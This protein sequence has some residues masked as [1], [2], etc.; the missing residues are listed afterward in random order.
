MTDRHKVGPKEEEKTNG[1][2][3]GPEIQRET[4]IKLK[5]LL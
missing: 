2:K 4:D 3:L 1:H 5:S